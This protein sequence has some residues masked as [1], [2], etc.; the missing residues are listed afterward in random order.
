ML[1]FSYARFAARTVAYVQIG[2]GDPFT[3]A[4]D[5]GVR[6]WV[7]RN[8]LIDNWPHHTV[9]E[10]RGAVALAAG[11]EYEIEI[12]YYD[13][14]GAASMKLYWSADYLERE[15]VPIFELV[16]VVPTPKQLRELKT[17]TISSA[18][19]MADDLS[20]RTTYMYHFMYLDKA[21]EPIKLNA[22]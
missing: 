9:V 7:N 22:R 20:I 19:K 1:L 16:E 17:F 15:V 8:L 14:V 4:S 13:I 3:T 12:E 11:V 5:E 2:V 21:I 18:G 10:N 6:V